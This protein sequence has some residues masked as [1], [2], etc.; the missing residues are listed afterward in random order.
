MSRVTMSYDVI[1]RSTSLSFLSERLVGEPVAAVMQMHAQRRREALDLGEPLARDAHRAD[2]ER[3]PELLAPELLALGERASRSPAPSCRGPCRRRGSRRSRGRR[4]CA[5]SRGRAPG[6]RRARRSSPAAPAAAG[7]ACRRRAGS[8]APGRARRSPISS[9]SSSISMPRDRRA[10]GRRHRRPPCASRGTCSAR[11]TSDGRSACQRSPANDDRRLRGGE[12]AQ[13]VLRQVDVAD[14]EL[15]VELREVRGRHEAGRLCCLRPCGAARG[16]VGADARRRAH[17]RRRQQHRHARLLE[18]RHQVL[19]EER[20]VVGVELDLARLVVVERDPALGEQRRE[21]LELRGE[22]AVRVAVAHELEALAALPEERR[23]QA[24]RRVVGGVQPQLECERVAAGR[25]RRGGSRAATA[26]PSARRGRCRPSARGA[27]RAR[28]SSAR[29]AGRA[30][31]RRGRSGTR[32]SPA[33]GSAARGG[34]RR[35]GRARSGRPGAAAARR[36]RRSRAG[37]AAAIAS[38]SACSE[39]SSVTPQNANQLLPPR[40]SCG[41]TSPSETARWA[42][43]DDR[44]RRL[45][46]RTCVAR[47]IGGELDQLPDAQLAL[48]GAEQAQLAVP[49]DDFERFTRELRCGHDPPE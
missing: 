40:R 3:R 43:A 47:R 11:P 4:A 24:E 10:R 41:W 12:R 34:R 30:G 22:V 25:A 9:P 21:L 2:D 31:R 17:P 8:R 36:S 23:G 15:P 33:S 20:R 26:T 16:Q 29:P 44:E 1:T 48:G 38:S 37:A 39:S 46:A 35:G 6:T 49:P 7:S 13:L 19:E 32:P 45:G 18:Q 27:A 42:S 14:R 28:R 5:A